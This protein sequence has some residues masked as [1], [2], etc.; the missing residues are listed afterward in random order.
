VNVYEGQLGGG[1]FCFD[2]GF[3]VARF[4]AFLV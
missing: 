1:G 3:N 2:G 4:A